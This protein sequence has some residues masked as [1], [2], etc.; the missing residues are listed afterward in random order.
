MRG[1]NDIVSI[2]I[3]IPVPEALQ[4]AW[5]VTCS[6]PFQASMDACSF[7]KWG[8]W[9][10]KLWVQSFTSY[11]RKKRSGCHFSVWIQ[12]LLV[13]LPFFVILSKLLP[14]LPTSWWW[15][16]P[17]LLA[18]VWNYMDEGIGFCHHQSQDLS[19]HIS[20]PP[21]ASCQPSWTHSIVWVWIF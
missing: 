20:K 21:F 17:L 3:N 6:Q 4:R 5:M 16:D 1:I 10:H 11:T 19:S 9:G 7:C 18:Q 8:W 13:F 15:S 14:S 2:S 12:G